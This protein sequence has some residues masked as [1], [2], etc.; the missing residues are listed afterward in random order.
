MKTIK[1]TDVSG[2]GPAK[3]KVLEANGIDSVEKFVA[4]DASV[5]CE[6]PGF[7]EA[8][9]VNLLKN[10]QDLLDA[11]ETE[12]EKEPVVEEETVT[13]AVEETVTEAVEETAIEESSGPE[14]AK[15]DKKKSKGKKS[16]DK[17]S[18]NKKSKDKKSKKKKSGKKKKK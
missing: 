7:K 14:A 6:I 9:T 13:E 15:K 4:T 18:K 1:L 2:I 10:A 17:K 11:P 12:A 16:K 5:I 8:L 3:A